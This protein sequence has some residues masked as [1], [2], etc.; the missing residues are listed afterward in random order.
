MSLEHAYTGKQNL[1][2]KF[3]D[4]GIRGISLMKVEDFK[5]EF[6]DSLQFS[7]L[8]SSLSPIIGLTT[9][10]R[11]G[12]STNFRANTVLSLREVPFGMTLVKKNSLLEV[13]LIVLQGV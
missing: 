6:G 11:N 2:W 9:S 5:D 12:I 3:N 4:S 1:S 7:N 8:T 10:F 13:Y